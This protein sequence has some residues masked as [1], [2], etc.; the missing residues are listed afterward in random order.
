MLKKIGGS[1]LATAL[2]GA[3]A[4]PAL[5]TDL[6]DPPG[7]PPAL[8]QRGTA[9]LKAFG[10]ER[11][12]TLRLSCHDA[13]KVT[14]ATVAP[15]RRL[16]TTRFA[17]N[18][19]RAV[20]RMRMPGGVA[21][22]ARARDSI[23]A[24]A[25][26]VSGG[27]RSSF[28]LETRRKRDGVAQLADISRWAVPP[29]WCTG[30]GFTMTIDN[31]TRFHAEWGETVWWRPIGLERDLRSGAGTWRYANYWRSHRAVPG[32]GYFLTDGSG[33]LEFTWTV[34]QSA[35]YVVARYGLSV[36]PAYEV[37]TS[38]GGYR[39]YWLDV[40]SGSGYSGESYVDRCVVPYT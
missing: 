23:E 26:V 14:L 35:P 19:G 9:L 30:I 4:A 7:A 3:G 32:D 2:L 38:R 25:T 10:N 37:Y 40:T 29:A 27:E 20:A 31:T 21:G 1:L 24:V 12:I 33:R 28:D 18:R 15:K 13:G 8:E 11:M 16:G 17:C 34:T 36:D 6:P 39:S 5:A 22:K